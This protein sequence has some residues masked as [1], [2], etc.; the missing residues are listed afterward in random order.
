MVSNNLPGKEP[1][2][3]TPSS[4]GLRLPLDLTQ[5]DCRPH[6]QAL[7]SPIPASVVIRLN[8]HGTLGVGIVTDQSDAEDILRNRLKASRPRLEILRK[9]F[10][11]PQ[12]PKQEWR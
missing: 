12:F 4:Q 10:T 7:P 1:Q 11:C 2:I 6:V 3:K 8:V 9:M 5:H